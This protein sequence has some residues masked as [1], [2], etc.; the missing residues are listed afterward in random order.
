MSRSNYDIIIIGGG[1]NGLTAAAMLGSKGKK[2]IVLER[3]SEL[4]GLASGTE[5]HPGYRTNGLLHDTSTVRNKVIKELSLEKYGLKINHQ[6]AGYAALSK[7][8]EH[9]VLYGNPEKTIESISQISPKDADAYKRY[10]AFFQKIGPFISGLTDN[11]PPNLN[12]FGFSEILALMKKGWGLKRLGNKT[13]ME[14]LKVAPMAIADFLNEYFE[15]EFIKAAIAG[16]SVYASFTGPWSPY[17]TLNQIIYECNSKIQVEG[18]AQ[19]LISSLEQAIGDAGVVVRTEADVVSII[20]E[21]STVKGV[22]LDGGEEIMAP[23]ILST[24]SPK[25]TFL[26]LMSSSEIGNKLE[27]GFI[28]Y[29]SRGTTAKVNLALNK[30]VFF[31]DHK[32]I[33]YGRTGNSFDEME[34]AFD[35][36]KYR[37]FSEDPILD[38]HIPTIKNP[39][40]A[41]NGHSVLSVLVHFAPYNLKGGWTSDAKVKLGENVLN[42]LEQYFHD[43]KNSIVA[44]EVL[45]PKDLEN[46]YGL[47]EGHIYHGEHAVDQILTRP[48]PECTQYE[49]PIKGL[50]LG[51]SGSHPGGGL[52]GMP[53]LLAAKYLLSKRA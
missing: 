27:H 26:S 25:L 8:G 49:T 14:L 19:A 35:S 5:F 44:L 22:R 23:N 2:V 24:C 41:P 9:L 45:T 43:I 15:T 50:Y 18:G 53:G 32:E 51:G 42:T 12:H 6:R 40:L 48:H 11:V 34:K 4:G 47:P 3:R 30:E 16:P 36:S 29:R 37:Q 20:A 39:E 46:Q 17:T 21:D 7:G 38:I 1:H 31:G 52:T 13:M 28:H 33:E 10:D